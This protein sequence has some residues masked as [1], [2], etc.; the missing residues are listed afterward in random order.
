M[1]MSVKYQNDFDNQKC[2]KNPNI[3][4]SFDGLHVCKN[5]GMTFGQSFSSQER[6][7]YTAE[8]I[9]QRKRTEPTWRK[10]G[11][12]TI[13]GSVK[14]DAKGKQIKS[15]GKSL[16]SRLRKIQGSLINSTERNY[17]EAKPK[18]QA[19][20]EKINVPDYIQ[21]TAWKI[22]KEVAKQKITMGRT[23]DGFV[24]AS[25]YASIRIHNFPRLLEELAE[26]LATPVR[27]I[28]QSLGLIVRKVF[29][30]LELKYHPVSPIS[31]IYRFGNKL[32]LS[33]NI[34]EKS[35]KIFKNASKNGLKKIGKD[36]KGLAAAVIYIA[37][38]ETSEKRTQ[39][40]ISKISRITEVTLRTRVKQIRTHL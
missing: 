12:R 9:K 27:M 30:I 39:S 21:E 31:L 14:I 25:L 20:S 36:P 5:C 8:E 11:P 18:L 28:H 40:Q 35:V 23:I 37:A 1:E 32:N 34:Q 22:Y 7:A 26:N 4:T 2:C 15:K 17:W 33:S 19:F 13:I 16:F 24:C 29:P 6:R 3:G 38:K 10:Y